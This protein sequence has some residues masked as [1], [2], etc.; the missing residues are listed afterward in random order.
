MAIGFGDNPFWTFSL[1][2]YAGDG[3]AQSCIALQDRH[4]VDVNLLLFCTWIGASGRGTLT[5]ADFAVILDAAGP[6]NR[7]VVC[8]LRAARRWMKNAGDGVDPSLADALRR[9]IVDIEVDCEHAE[10]LA[11]A[12]LVQRPPAERP[13][14]ER[15]EAA[16]GNLAGYFE[17]TGVMIRDADVGDLAA[18][19]GAAIPELDG[20]LLGGK[21]ARLA[22]QGR[23][24]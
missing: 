18:I 11:L 5:A 3:V 22:G 9:M 1:A 15:V 17:R 14:E 6:W 8:R 13:A 2:I 19:V 4:D 23:A 7:E 21:L 24:P 10:Q 20:G 12:N 16:I